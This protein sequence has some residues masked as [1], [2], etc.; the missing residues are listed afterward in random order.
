MNINFCN[1]FNENYDITISYEPFYVYDF[2]LLANGVVEA[3][4]YMKDIG[5]N[6]DVYLDSGHT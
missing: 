1:S 3:G 6:E 4:E 2:G 5:N